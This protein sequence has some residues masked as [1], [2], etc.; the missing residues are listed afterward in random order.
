VLIDASATDKPLELLAS[1]IG[2]CR[3][4][5]VQHDQGQPPRVIYAASE[6]NKQIILCE[7]SDPTY[8]SLPVN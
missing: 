3:K 2:V 4:I 1:F 6:K 7:L 8:G 5:G